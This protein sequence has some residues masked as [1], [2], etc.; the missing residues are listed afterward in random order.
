MFDRLMVG[1]YILVIQS[2]ESELTSK[3]TRTNKQ[4]Y[5][6]ETSSYMNHYGTDR[7]T[8]VLCRHTQRNQNQSMTL[9]SILISA[10]LI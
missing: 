5:Q 9:Q 10:H 1:I 3:T 2:K 8:L 7:P 4:A 6:E